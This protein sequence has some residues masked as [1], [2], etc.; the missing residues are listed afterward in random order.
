MQKLIDGKKIAEKILAETAKK[1]LAL[2]KK[3]ITP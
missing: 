2:K 3:N 1:V